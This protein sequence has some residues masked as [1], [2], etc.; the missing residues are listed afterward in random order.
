MDI[1]PIYRDSPYLDQTPSP[2]TTTQLVNEAV[3]VLQATNYWRTEDGT[4]NWIINNVRISQTADGL[5]R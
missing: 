3:G 5:V 4:E 2:T 1:V